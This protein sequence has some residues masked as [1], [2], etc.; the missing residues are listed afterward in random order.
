MKKQDVLRIV[1][2]SLV[3]NVILILTICFLL[4]SAFQDLKSSPDFVISWLNRMVLIASISTAFGF[5][6]SLLLPL[7]L[8]HPNRLKIAIGSQIGS[9][10]ILWLLLCWATLNGLPPDEKRTSAEIGTGASTKNLSLQSTLNFLVKDFEHNYLTATS[11][12]R[13]KI[14]HATVASVDSILKYVGANEL[15]YSYNEIEKSGNSI[16][17]GKSG[18]YL[19][20][21]C[22]HGNYVDASKYLDIDSVGKFVL[23]GEIR[24]VEPTDGKRA[25]LILF[26]TQ[27]FLNETAANSSFAKVGLMN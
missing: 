23:T 27:R 19:S 4:G 3:L 1:A 21:Q 9:S 26:R 14:Y 20:I 2:L 18:E 25:N 22:K 13:P 12:N 10:L 16:T 11:A 17:F 24:L 7:M 8:Y 5:I 15:V 6:I